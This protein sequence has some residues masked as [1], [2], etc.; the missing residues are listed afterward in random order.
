MRYDKLQVNYDLNYLLI[1]LR[2]QIEDYQ[3]AYFLNK[4][5]FFIFKRMGKDLS[6]VINKDNIYFSAFHD[7]NTDL[8]RDSFLIRNKAIYNTESTKN[9]ELFFN[10]EISNIAF[11]IPEL[12]EF[13]YF[14]K[15]EGVWKK[16][17]IIS[18]KHFLNKMD[19]I[20]SETSIN[21]NTISSINNLVF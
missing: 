20:E 8:K 19:I 9:N 10:T 2:T 13:D 18:L 6:C 16:K 1:A 5:S 14:I 7:H 4:S 17:E 3:I 11:L 15:L 12:K 21:L